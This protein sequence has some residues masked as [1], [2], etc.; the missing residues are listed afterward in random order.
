[1]IKTILNKNIIKSG[2]VKPLFNNHILFNKKLLNTQNYAFTTETPSNPELD[3]IN[4]LIK[5]KDYQELINKYSSDCILYSESR[6]I[7]TEV[8]DEINF[9]KEKEYLKEINEII[10]EIRFS[11]IN[12]DIKQTIDRNTVNKIIRVNKYSVS[13]D[14]N[15]KDSNNII[16]KD[17]QYARYDNKTESFIISIPVI[18]F[19][20]YEDIIKKYKVD[21]NTFKAVLLSSK[22]AT[23][24][25]SFNENYKAYQKLITDAKE[26]YEAKIIDLLE[27]NFDIDNPNNSFEYIKEN[28]NTINDLLILGNEKKTIIKNK[29]SELLDISIIN[30]IKSFSENI[31]KLLVN[32]NLDKKDINTQ[33]KYMSVKEEIQ[34]ILAHLYSLESRYKKYFYSSANFIDI[35]PVS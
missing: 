32:I 21:Y 23:I 2:V 8:L 33:K 22:E 34:N 7:V 16:I 14:N 1:M 24:A 9:L 17:N 4:K 3:Y 27:N 29:L 10:K 28:L 31:N 18:E 11:E 30:D 26:N 6:E 12:E 15:E 20:A 35:D 13:L 19:E 5:Q 25:K